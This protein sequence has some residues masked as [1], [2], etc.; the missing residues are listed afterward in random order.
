MPEAL[1]DSWNV[2]APTFITDVSGDGVVDMVVANGG[3]STFTAEVR[4]SQSKRKTTV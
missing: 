2:F 4:H 1:T 3:D